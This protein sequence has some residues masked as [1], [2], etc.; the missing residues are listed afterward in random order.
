MPDSCRLRARCRSSLSCVRF[1]S[2]LRADFRLAMMYNYVC[3]G[4]SKDAS[5]LYRTITW[6]YES[7][8]TTT[9]D[10]IRKGD[11]VA[12]AWDCALIIVSGLRLAVT[13]TYLMRL[14]N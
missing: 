1:R 4:P 11:A 6:Y 8:C 13:R 5:A 2:F 9:C 14:N 3:G 10:L 7:N 12:V